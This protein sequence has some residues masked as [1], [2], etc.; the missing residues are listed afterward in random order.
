A[1]T[2]TTRLCVDSTQALSASRVEAGI[3]VVGRLFVRVRPAKRG[4]DRC[5]LV[6]G[7]DGLDPVLRHRLVPTGLPDRRP[8]AFAASE[9]ALAERRPRA[10]GV[11]A[12][13]PGAGGEHGIAGRLEVRRRDEPDELVRDRPL[14]QASTIEVE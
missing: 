7:N 8:G 1:F 10:A 4:N 3:D 13:P 14:R 12:D 11:L 6:V 2:R 9:R 5:E